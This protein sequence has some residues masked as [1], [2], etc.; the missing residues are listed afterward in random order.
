MVST[1]FVCLT[2]DLREDKNPIK[3]F[4]AIFS[5]SSSSLTL[6]IYLY[7]KGDYENM[8]EELYQ[9]SLDKYDPNRDIDTNWRHFREGYQILIDTCDPRKVINT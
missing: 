7:S 9:I 5:G 1:F 3:R 4:L 8:N 6:L 2:M